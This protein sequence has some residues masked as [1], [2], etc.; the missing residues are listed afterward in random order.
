MEEILSQ[1]DEGSSEVVC[2]NQIRALVPGNA[3]A[4]KAI[5]TSLASLEH[6]VSPN[7]YIP[8]VDCACA[9]GKVGTVLELVTKCVTAS[10][11]APLATSSKRGRPTARAGKGG[12]KGSKGSKNSSDSD[13]SIHYDVALGM[14]DRVIRN[15]SMSNQSL[16]P[17]HTIALRSTLRGAMDV[18]K[19]E[20][21]DA[22]TC[23]P[24]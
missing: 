19:N 12:G 7:Q 3:K 16:L 9:W 4:I 23:V 18:L 15:M 17:K 8:L 1:Y 11:S 14:L 5:T 10:L 20:L 2:I 22:D 6:T 24:S 13:S 21:E